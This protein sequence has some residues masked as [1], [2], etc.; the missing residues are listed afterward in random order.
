MNVVS[1]FRP[2]FRRTFRGRQKR[3]LVLGGAVAALLLA[4]ARLDAQDAAASLS[5][6]VVRADA[7]AA[8]IRRVYVTVAALDSPSRLSVITD[9]LGRFVFARLPAGRYTLSAS[10][11]A[12][13]TA[14]LGSTGIGRPGTPLVL[15]PGARVDNVRLALTR[16]AVVAGTVRD[17]TGA[18]AANVDVLV[19]AAATSAGIGQAMPRELLDSVDPLQV[20]TTLTDD[21]GGY[22]VYGLPPGDYFV[23]ALPGS[24]GGSLLEPAA[25]GPPRG[26]AAPAAGRAAAGGS[27]QYTYAP[28]FYPGTPRADEATPVHVGPGEE[29]TGLDFSF[30]LVRTASVAGSIAGP[31]VK[32]GSTVSM[33]AIGPP[34]PVSSA[35]SGV[36]RVSA[37]GRFEFPHV[38]PGRYVLRA[39][40]DSEDG[41]LRAHTELLVNGERV[42]GVSLVLQPTMRFG[43]RVRLDRSDV[44]LP[45]IRL[46]LRRL[47]ASRTDPFGPPVSALGWLDRAVSPGPAL[48]A[49]D[50][51]FS[52]P[53]ILPGTFTLTISPPS[54]L[55]GWWLESAMAGGRDLL[56]MPLEF[57]TRLGT[58]DDAVLTLTNRRTELTGRLQTPAGLPA[59]DY[60]VIVCSADRAHWYPGA[61]RTRAVRPASDGLFRVEE[62]PAGDYLVAAVTDVVDGEWQRAS[63]L[64][65][66]AAFAVPVTVR[67]G[68]STRQDLRIAGG[69]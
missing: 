16:G 62:L 24:G 61:R 22:R 57:G 34:L 64:G 47:N 30:D 15:E 39:A 67:A 59:T 14:T 1:S 29:R 54:A 28:V 9:D 7:P 42:Q 60:V 41:P 56:D 68:Q 49:A 35:R 8:P 63:F 25:D 48:S 11:P 4:P 33:L 53:L 12:F 40:G 17:T 66:L 55:S 44:T 69:R 2:V 10:K 37:D 46:A 50:G 65:Q 31:G 27:P 19:A 32:P 20:R 6:V 38:G 13:L 18:P 52:I 36:A 45:P 51:A 58:I 43:G 23:A 5:G 26:P 3:R 21:R